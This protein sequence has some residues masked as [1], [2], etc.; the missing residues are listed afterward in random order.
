[1]NKEVNRMEIRKVSTRSLIIGIAIELLVAIIMGYAVGSVSL[2][3]LYKPLLI[4]VTKPFVC[5]NGEMTYTQHKEE[6]GTDTITYIGF[7]CEDEETGIKTD[8]DP[9]TVFLYGT[10]LYSLIF[11]AVFLISTYLYWYSNVGPAKNEG[12]HLW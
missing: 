8:L 6:V 12:L 9:N 11:F 3:V 5:P 4:A 7:H 2:G 10:P 1:M